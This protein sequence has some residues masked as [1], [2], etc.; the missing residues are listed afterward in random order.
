ME[1]V[2]GYLGLGNMGHPMAMRIADAGYN[3]LVFDINSE[4]LIDFRERQ[5]PVAE[6]V[7]DLGDKADNN[8]FL[9]F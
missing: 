2:V 9:T 5:I 4:A 8:L 6:S 3:L 1:K 7:R